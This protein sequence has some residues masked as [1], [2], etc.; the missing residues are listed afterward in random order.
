MANGEPKILDLLIWNIFGIPSV[1]NG[2]FFFLL[3]FKCIT[4]YPRGYF[5]VNYNRCSK[6]LTNCVRAYIRFGP[7]LS[8]LVDTERIRINLIY[9]PLN[10][11][12]RN[13]FNLAEVESDFLLELIPA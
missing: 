3:E 12:T 13:N 7:I 8:Y 6:S 5:V 9:V 11:K 2:I 1:G 4:I 10:I